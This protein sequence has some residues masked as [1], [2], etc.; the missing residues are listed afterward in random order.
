MNARYWENLV[1]SMLNLGLLRTGG[2]IPQTENI[3]KEEI[4][5][6]NS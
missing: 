5:Q 1:L 4:E 6:Y 2:M 3:L